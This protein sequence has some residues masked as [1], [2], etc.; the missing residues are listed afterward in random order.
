[1]DSTSPIMQISL[2]GLLTSASL[3]LGTCYNGG[4][5]WGNQVDLEVNLAH[6]VCDNHFSKITFNEA[7]KSVSACYRIDST[8]MVEFRLQRVSAGGDMT[9]SAAD[10][11]DGLQKE[12]V[13]CQYGGHSSY[14]NWKFT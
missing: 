4:E 14:T 10:C 13:G 7:T 8:K 3:V 5:Q 6:D 11:W 9:I 12:I 2:L 1:M